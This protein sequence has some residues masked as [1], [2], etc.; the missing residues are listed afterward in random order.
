MQMA[1]EGEISRDGEGGWRRE[2]F[3]KLKLSALCRFKY[4]KFLR[5]FAM[6]FFG[7]A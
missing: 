1:G 2:S 6:M 3:Y 7:Q 4:E 5:L